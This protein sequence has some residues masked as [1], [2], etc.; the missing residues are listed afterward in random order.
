QFV[1]H[2]QP[3]IRLD[4]QQVQGY[5]ALVRW[6]HPEFGLLYPDRFI[7]LAERSGFIVD[8][9]WEVLRLACEALAGWDVQGRETRLA[10]NVSA[11]Q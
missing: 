10:V 1:L 6:D 5:E 11:L 8:L 4:T 9:G 2:Y 3:Q 7:D